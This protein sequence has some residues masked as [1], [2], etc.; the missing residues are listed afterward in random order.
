MNQLKIFTGK[1][2]GA[3]KVAIYG[4]EGIGKSTLAAHFPR[5][6]FIDTEGS[7]RHMDVSRTEKPTS[8]TMLMEQVEY[9]RNDPGVCST[10]IIDTADWAE[11]LC[12]DGICASKKLSGIEDMG[13]GKGYVY[14]AEEYGRL[15]NMLEE[16]VGRG[17]HVVLT[18]HAM[19][20]KFEQP[21]EMGAYD[22]WELKL[23]K[24]TAALVKE[25]SDL[26]LFANYK[27]MSVATDEK[28]K[29]FKAQG[30]RRVMYTS[31]HPCW[32]AKNRLGLPEELPLDFAALAQYIGTPAAPVSSTPPPPPVSSPPVPP[33][34]NVPAA[35]P[36][37]AGQTSPPSPPQPPQAA[38]TPELPDPDPA[39]A[40]PQQ[41]APKTQDN[42]A[43]L[44]ALQ[45]LMRADGVLDYE[46]QAAIGARGYF[47][48]DTPLKN[49]PADFIQ[50]VLVGAWKQVLGWIQANKP[51][52]PF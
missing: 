16:V 1:A 30:G 45:D 21:D 23:Q 48:E 38:P 39:P 27:T 5:P 15:L 52:L 40:P 43:A 18:A 19:M 31:H 20:R 49:L 46:V 47:P 6:V 44:K 41:E 42:A 51:I 37:S 32:D 3:L 8:W 11:Q 26:L 10:L 29:K 36:G 24:K 7:T 4:P 13:Y 28:G 9:I 17:V 35:A 12:M 14:L 33:K 34:T 50:G 22:R 25:W 2:G